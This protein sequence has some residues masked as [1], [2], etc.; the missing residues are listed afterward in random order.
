MW[1]STFRLD[2]LH[3]GLAILFCNLQ[4]AIMIT[5]LDEALFLYLWG[6]G[7]CNFT[8]GVCFACLNYKVG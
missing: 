6:E 7:V 2:L 4:F 8:L 1:Y 3:L 5:D